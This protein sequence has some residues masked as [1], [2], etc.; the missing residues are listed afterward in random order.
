[1]S[2]KIVYTS[3]LPEWGKSFG[4]FIVFYRLNSKLCTIENDSEIESI[5]QKNEIL[6]PD[7][8]NIYMN[9]SNLN[10]IKNLNKYYS[11]YYDLDQRLFSKKCVNRNNGKFSNEYFKNS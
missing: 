5:I 7:K 6:L 10:E 3:T 1:M 9:L 2:L 11:Q 8:E 4:Q